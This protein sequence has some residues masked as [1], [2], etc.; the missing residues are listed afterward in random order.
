MPNVVTS[1]PPAKLNLFLELL[2]KRDDGFHE[3]DTIML[4]ID[5]CDE[6][7]LART[8]AS[9]ISLSI[10][11]LPS[12]EVVAAELGVD[13]N[14]DDGKNLLAIPSDEKNLVVR[15][16]RRFR[17]HFDTPGGFHCD[18]LKRIPA[19][20][21][22]GG[23]SSDAAAALRCA[24]ALHG[25]PLHNPE[26]TVLAAEIGSDVPFFLGI[27]RHSCQAARAQGR[28]E[29]LSQV[30]LLSQIDMVVVFPSVCLST[31]RVYSQ[32]T[33]PTEIVPPDAMIAALGRGDLGGIAAGGLNRLQE[34]AV[35]IAK[36]IDEILESMW[37]I[38]LIGCQLTGSGS[39][40]FGLARNAVDA[41]RGAEQLRS[42]LLPGS[43]V[44]SVSSATV[45]SSVNLVITPNG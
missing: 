43:R 10:G 13:P 12:L 45:P 34:P 40:C 11:W 2:G 44:A 37:H 6:M 16:L 42:Q 25:I 19:G 33:I 1:R 27:D 7:R 3:I 39:A 36:Q 23:A 26:L 38:G 28:G 18:L 35:K 31:A 20:A 24:A 15:A 22:M 8:E 17:D 30:S 41:R 14:S 5:W 9:D 21:G 29:K 32:A 4:P